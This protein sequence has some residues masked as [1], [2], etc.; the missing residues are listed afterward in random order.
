ML[1]LA[2]VQKVRLQGSNI[3]QARKYTLFNGKG[4]TN[5]NWVQ[6]FVQKR[7]ISAVKRVEFFSERMS[8]IILRSHS[9]HVIVLNVLAQQRRKLVM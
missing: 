5:M 3:E 1:H 6:F 2:G 8:Y 9:Y 4:M 7:I